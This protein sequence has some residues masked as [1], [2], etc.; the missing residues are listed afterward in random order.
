MTAVSPC[1]IS[2][3]IPESPANVSHKRSSVPFLFTWS[4]AESVSLLVHTNIVYIAEAIYALILNTLLFLN[5]TFV[6]MSVIQLLLQLLLSQDSLFSPLP[7]C[8]RTPGGPPCST[9]WALSHNPAHISVMF[10]IVYC[11][12]VISI[13]LLSRLPCCSRVETLPAG[14]LCDVHV[15]LWACFPPLRLRRSR[16][17]PSSNFFFLPPWFFPLPFCLRLSLVLKSSGTTVAVTADPELLFFCLRLS[18]L[19]LC[20]LWGEATRRPRLAP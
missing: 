9:S 19:L 18:M 8:L 15:Y 4:R 1:L 13:L 12:V 11:P 2:D 7:P 17:L 20:G 10:H 14:P 16:Y 6:Y 3:L 5:C